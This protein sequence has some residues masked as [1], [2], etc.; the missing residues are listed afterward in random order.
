MSARAEQFFIRLERV[1]CKMLFMALTAVATVI[2][3]DV[4]YGGGSGC[5]SMI[6]DL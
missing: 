5:C 2:I 3:V 4:G 6:S 1:S